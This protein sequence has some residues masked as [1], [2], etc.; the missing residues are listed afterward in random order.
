MKITELL[1]EANPLDGLVR[2]PATGTWSP[3][4]EVKPTPQV[5]R[6][7]GVKEPIE[8]IDIDW[9]QFKAG[10]TA[11]S[12]FSKEPLV[13]RIDGLVYLGIMGAPGKNK[14]FEPVRMAWTVDDD[15][16]GF[17]DRAAN[18]PSGSSTWT[19]RGPDKGF[20]GGEYVAGYGGGYRGKSSA[21]QE[22]IGKY[23]IVFNHVSFNPAN[24]SQSASLIA[25]EL[26]H[27]GFHMVRSLPEILE[28]IPQPV[29]DWAASANSITTDIL[30]Y[31]KFDN[32]DRQ[33]QEH[34]L[35]YS[36]EMNNGHVGSDAMFRSL[37]E[38]RTF[39]KIYWIVANAARDYIQTQP[40]PKGGL[41][42]LRDAVDEFTPD[43]E[44]IT[45]TKAPG[46]KVEI[47]ATS[48]PTTNTT[49]TTT[50]TTISPSVGTPTSA[51]VPASAPSLGAPTSVV[52]TPS[53]N[54]SWQDIYQANKG[55]IGGDPNLIRPG[56]KLTIP[57]H[58]EYIVKPGDTL[59]Q[60]AANQRELNNE[61]GQGSRNSR[62]S[63]T[64]V[65]EQDDRVLDQIKRILR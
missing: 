29:R 48:K 35:M 55:V 18:A 32:K 64:L 56:Q 44:K 10:M 33:G 38:I 49:A 54:I 50:S 26:R 36:V 39:R 31:Y 34:L 9:E 30:D 37:E 60:I 47:I 1:A 42:A 28:K 15:G 46:G 40:V 41:K 24:I 25:H 7:S 5:N 62:L 51:P 14:I 21:E 12:L 16:N 23:D 58:G 4:P 52:K 65:R 27:R 45:I 3:K 13:D 53:S 19:R 2:D 17:M 43:N 6:A 57:G 11:A 61:L 20:I 63:K 8:N 22:V 59:S